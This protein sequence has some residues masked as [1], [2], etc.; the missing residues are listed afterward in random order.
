MVTSAIKNLSGLCGLF[1]ISASAFSASQSNSTVLHITG[2]IVADPCNILPGERD[3]QVT[4]P[5]DGTLRTHNVSYRAASNTAVS[6]GN[7]DVSMQYLNP[8]RSLAILKVEYR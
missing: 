8:E 5:Q 6:A 4:C 3:I 2:Q 7:V 1:M